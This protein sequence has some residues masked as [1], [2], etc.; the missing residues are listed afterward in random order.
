VTSGTRLYGYL[1]NAPRARTRL[2][3]GTDWSPLGRE[4]NADRYYSAMKTTFCTAMKFSPSEVRGFMGTR[5][6]F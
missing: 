6:G 3:Y 4:L 1:H 2:M 5:R